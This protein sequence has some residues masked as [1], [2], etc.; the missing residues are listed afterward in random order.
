MP[1]V[2]DAPRRTYA[3]KSAGE[4]EAD[5]RAALVDACLGLV[6][7][8]GW[9]ELTID[10]LCREAGLNKRYF[11]ESFGSLDEVVAAVTAQLADEAIAAALGAFDADTPEDEVNARAVTALVDAL[12]DDPRRA[13]V[14]LGAVATSEVA[15]AHRVSAIRRIITTVADTGRELHWLGED[16]SA[17]LTAAMVFGGTS[18]TVLD[19]LDGRIDCPRTEFIAGLIELWDGIA[20]Q[21]ESRVKKN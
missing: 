21:A 18:Q 15:D 20:E 19:W 13:R 10:A 17:D 4:R 7:E 8:H 6:A 16:P 9:R 11:Y 14:L 1:A 3:G 12:T 2:K 5:R